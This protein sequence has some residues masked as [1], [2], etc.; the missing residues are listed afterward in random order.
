MASLTQWTWIWVNS[1]SWQWTG[2]PGVLQFMGSQ[3]VRHNWATELNCN[4]SE[5]FP[6][7]SDGKES[8]CN[9]RDLGLIPGLGR[10]TEEGHGNPLQYSCLENSKNRGAWW[11]TV[12]GVT[13]SQTQLN[14][15]HFHFSLWHI[16]STNTYQRLQFI[17]PLC[18]EQ[19]RQDTYL[20]R[21]LAEKTYVKQSLNVYCITEGSQLIP[22]CLEHS[23]FSDWKIC[24]L[25]I[26][27]QF[28]A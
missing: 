6:G 27:S 24:L 28:W 18:L 1:M 10:S 20:A 7:S 12:H 16:Y 4:I 2:R 11:A 9:T 5:G 14:K 25:W 19:D 26:L 22:F 15:S 3:R 13:K 23:W 8:A 17:Q 21:S